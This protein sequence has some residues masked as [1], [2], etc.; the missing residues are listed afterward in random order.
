MENPIDGIIPDFSVFGAEFTQW[1]EKLFGALWAIAIIVAL[2]YLLLGVVT[3]A[4]SGDNPHDYSQ[5]RGRAIK[6]LVAVVIL[7]AFGVVVGAVF[8]VAT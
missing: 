3:M 7:A 8:A 4:Q 5:G 2:V 6:A 1:W